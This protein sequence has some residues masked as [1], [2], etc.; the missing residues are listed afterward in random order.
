MNLK[1]CQTLACDD[2]KVG[3]LEQKLAV[4]NDEAIFTNC[5]IEKKRFDHFH[6]VKDASVLVVFWLECISQQGENPI[7]MYPSQLKLFKPILRLPFYRLLE[8]K[9]GN[10][11]IDV[12]HL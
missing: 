3:K 9:A 12:I 7:V 1:L 10:D 5:L 8:W 4:E 2:I 11:I 6:N